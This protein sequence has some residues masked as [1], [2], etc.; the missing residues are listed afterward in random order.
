MQSLKTSTLHIG[1]NLH[2]MRGFPDGCVDLIYLDP[3]FCTSR[4]WHATPGSIA[5]GVRFT[6]KWNTTVG[7]LE[8]PKQ[9]ALVALAADSHSPAMASYL[10][11]MAQR[12][13]E[14]Y[15]VLKPTGSLYLHCDD[16]AD[17][18]LRVAL[19]GLFGASCRVNTVTWKRNHAN[20]AVTR[21]YGRISDTIL[22][23]AKQPAKATWSQPYGELSKRELK[24]YKKDNEGRFYKCDNLT[25]PKTPNTD[26]ARRFEWKGTT[27]SASR[28]W[29]HSKEAMDA[30]YAKGLIELGKNGK[31]K[32]SGFKRYLDGHPG[33]KVQ[34]IWTDIYPLSGKNKE[35]TGWP[36]QKPL[37]LLE[38]IIK[39]SSN[40]GDL[41]LD[42]FAG[43]GTTLVAAEQLNRQWIGIEQNPTAA[44]VLQHRLPNTN[45]NIA[46][47][48]ERR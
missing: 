19:D 15:R 41:V 9:T 5:E 35:R 44:S 28:V 1:D 3:P 40:P 29:A 22:F 24:R 37:T 14:C 48:T 20:N 25:A 17:S 32:L 27:P 38:R 11:F 6:D 42:P 21:S 30:L 46:I 4:T 39:A 31:A 47:H 45:I 10:H 18:Y 34:S 2:V 8:C 13:Q 12:L 43:C 16:T 33:A 7:E 36:T 23:Y 26:N